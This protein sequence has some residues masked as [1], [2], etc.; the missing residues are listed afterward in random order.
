MLTSGAIHPT[1]ENENIYS[2]KWNSYQSTTFL[3]LND[4]TCWSNYIIIRRCPQSEPCSVFCFLKLESWIWGIRQAGYQ[5]H[6]NQF[7]PKKLLTS[8]FPMW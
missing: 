8:L 6:S 1:I 2:L 5:F 7:Y 3:S 4:Q